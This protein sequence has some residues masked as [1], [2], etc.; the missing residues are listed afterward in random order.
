[1]PLVAPHDL[2]R[3]AHTEGWALG[4][5]NTSN[6]EV[7]QGILWAFREAQAPGIIQT[8]ETA[9]RYAGLPV[10]CEMIRGVAESVP[11]PVVLHLDHG[12]SA[13]ICIQCIDAGYHSVMI[14]GSALPL[15]ENI[16][17]TCRVVEYAHAKGVWVEGEVG[18]IPGREGLRSGNVGT[19]HLTDPGDAVT[20]ITDTHVDA[21]A[22][23]VGTIH[24][25]FR[26]IEKLQRERLQAIQARVPIPLVLHGGSGLPDDDIHAAIRFG[27]AKVNVD[28]E[29][30][31]AFHD[32]LFPHTET[33]PDHEVD[34]RALLT[35]A[36]D[37][38]QQRVQ[39][40]VTLFG[41]A[42]KAT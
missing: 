22:V 23:S 4:A 13:E 26:G 17:L 28:T 9:I 41:A 3:L 39:E 1:M 29:L 38:V 11:V 31:E 15:Q 5:F 21:L 36:R 33:T 34:P 42:G 24:G 37:A 7:T 27:V 6:L 16:A 32:A 2:F 35:P 10:L 20:F 30:R 25:A 8:S 40:K 18:A 14:D 19:A 12:K